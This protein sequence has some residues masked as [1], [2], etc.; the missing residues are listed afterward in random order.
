MTARKPKTRS[1]A[2]KP[3]LC[4][5]CRTMP[6]GAKA[7]IYPSKLLRRL[8]DKE[9]DELSVIPSDPREPEAVRRTGPWDRTIL[10]HQCEKRYQRYDDHAIKV[11]A[12]D[13]LP[14][15]PPGAASV[16]ANADASILKLF[17]MHV[18]WRAH[19]STLPELRCVDI[20]PRAERL[21]DLLIADDPGAPEEFGV[22]LQRFAPDP[23]D[24]HRILRVFDELAWGNGARFVFTQIGP[25]IATVTTSPQGVPREL[26][27]L[28][29]RPG[30]PATAWSPVESYRE[31]GFSREILKTI[32]ERAEFDAARKGGAP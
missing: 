5:L 2:P 13:H 30:Q 8:I 28:H 3:G 17:F 27:P 11:L 12:P 32:R 23:D 19:A 18:L 22:G 9:F 21:R 7:H 26:L 29:L 14:P 25:W 16:I 6:A 24:A 15:L 1:D 31:S 4:G 10:C 20:G